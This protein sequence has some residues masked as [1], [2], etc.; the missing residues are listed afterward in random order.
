MSSNGRQGAN[1]RQDW[2]TDPEV[3]ADL[4]FAGMQRAVTE[5]IEDHHRAGNPVAIWQD[6][7]VVLLY[8][9]G[10]T[11]PVETASPATETP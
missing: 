4:A 3:F 8:P 9:D 7:Q 5:A 10:S 2:R 6:G 1:G 11:R